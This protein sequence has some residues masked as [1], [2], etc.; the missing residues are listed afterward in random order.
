ME[1]LPLSEK[2]CNDF[3][4]SMGELLL[5]FSACWRSFVM[6]FLSVREVFVEVSQPMGSFV[7]ISPE[8]EKFCIEISHWEKVCG[9]LCLAEALWK[10][11]V[12]SQIDDSVTVAVCYIL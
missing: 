5:K 2:F 6:E 3:F 8:P 9:N 12:L 4:L 10:A 1:F 11:H 7:E